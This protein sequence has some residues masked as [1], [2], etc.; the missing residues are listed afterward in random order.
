[1]RQLD[2]GAST[3]IRQA[4]DSLY[5]LAAG[6]EASLDYPEEVDEDEATAQLPRGLA[7]GG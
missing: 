6:I 4:L 5:R 7:G 3:F 1:M 2:G